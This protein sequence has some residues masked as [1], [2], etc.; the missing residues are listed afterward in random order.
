MHGTEAKRRRS[1]ILGAHMNE[2]STYSKQRMALIGA[3]SGLQKVDCHLRI[4]DTQITVD[5]RIEAWKSYGGAQ[6]MLE[7]MRT[8]MAIFLAVPTGIQPN[9][10]TSIDVD[11][12]LLQEIDVGLYVNLKILRLRGNLL[13]GMSKVAGFDQL[14][15]LEAFDARDNLF[16]LDKR[17][18]TRMAKLFNATKHLKYLGLWTTVVPEESSKKRRS[19]KIAANARKR[20]SSL[21][22]GEQMT[23]ALALAAGSIELIT[24]EHDGITTSSNKTI[25]PGIIGD[26]ADEND[27]DQHTGARP[28]SVYRSNLLKALLPTL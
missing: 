14:K 5:E 9:I 20:R 18:V 11:G 28:G 13:S 4:L 10:V 15:H 17:A 3:I 27:T 21:R 26:E 2:E 25:R 23:D 8:K 22:G 24:T 1:S 19:M 12:Q 16:I 7:K 6:D